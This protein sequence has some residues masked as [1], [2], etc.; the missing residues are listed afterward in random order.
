MGGAAPSTSTSL[1]ES[2]LQSILSYL[3]EM[4]RADGELLTQL[5]R[6]KGE[7]GAV[8]PSNGKGDPQSQ[9]GDKVAGGK[10]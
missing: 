1:S 9:G 8:Q 3:D 2:K 6:A 5:S 7:R 10:E 4:E